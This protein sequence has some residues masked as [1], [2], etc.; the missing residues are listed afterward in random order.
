MYQPEFKDIYSVPIKSVDGEEMF[1]EQFR[2]KILVIVNTT[3]YC[4]YAD[5]WPF[6]AEIQEEYK[7]KNVQIVYVPTN[8]Y[9]YS[10]T[11]EEYKNGIQ[12]GDQSREYANRKYGVNWPFTELV[13]SRNVACTL[14]GDYYDSENL[15]WIEQPDE[16]ARFTQAPRD[17]IYRF[18]I[19]N[20]DVE[21]MSANFQKY[22][23]NSKGLPVACFTASAFSDSPGVQKNTGGEVGTREEEL[24]NF[25]KVL[26]EIIETD[27]CVGKYS[28][29][30]YRLSEDNSEILDQLM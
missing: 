11:Y 29:T 20:P 10:V 3:G 7:D 9:Y 22:I 28:Y 15:E 4:G 18:L 1:L 2:D 12:T 25:R 27:T 21:P 5:Q 14:N 8:D 24:L 30:P 17:H 6:L 23:T 19:P 26:D 16:H 13:S